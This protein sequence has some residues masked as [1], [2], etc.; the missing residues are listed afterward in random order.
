MTFAANASCA[1]Y[2]EEYC[3]DLPMTGLNVAIIVM[4]ALVLI[5]LGLYGLLKTSSSG[6]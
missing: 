6:E 5:G 2:L 1:Q 4:A 3:P